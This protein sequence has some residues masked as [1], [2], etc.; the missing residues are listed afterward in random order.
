MV[1]CSPALAYRALVRALSRQLLRFLVAGDHHAD[2]QQL[3]F[4]A[5]PMHAAGQHLPG[6]GRQPLGCRQL[7]QLGSGLGLGGARCLWRLPSRRG[8]AAEVEPSRCCERRNAA[9]ERSPRT[10]A[11]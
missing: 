4:F 6:F 2:D 5:V 9:A 7:R 11:S 1:S 10:S 8:A 3:H